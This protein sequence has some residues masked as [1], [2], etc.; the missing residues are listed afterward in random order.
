[1]TGAS[2]DAGVE[3]GRNAIAFVRTK[4]TPRRVPENA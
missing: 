2:H 4:G 1:M 3:H